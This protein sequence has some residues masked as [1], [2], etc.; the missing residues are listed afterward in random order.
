MNARRF[1]Y[2]DE[3][4]EAEFDGFGSSAGSGFVPSKPTRYSYTFRCLSDARRTEVHGH[5]SSDDPRELTEHDLTT[6]LRS[7]LFMTALR[8]RRPKRKK[9]E[10]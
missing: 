8:R 9:K 2:G 1:T 7:A 5:V 3:E 10:P 4:W 6:E